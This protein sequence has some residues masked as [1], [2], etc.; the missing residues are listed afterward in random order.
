MAQQATP[1]HCGPYRCVLLSGG[2]LH[3][4]QGTCIKG[5][6]FLHEL[7]GGV[8]IDI[9]RYEAFRRAEGTLSSFINHADELKIP[10]LA[11]T[12]IQDFVR[13]A[14]DPERRLFVK[15]GMPPLEIEAIRQGLREVISSAQSALTAAPS[16][17][18]E[19][20]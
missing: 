8:T 20:V 2:I 14:T 6:D 5:H 18:H 17:V 19:L 7:C 1:V 13:V 15:P 12:D 3:F 9:L 10:V 4:H 16:T 11:I